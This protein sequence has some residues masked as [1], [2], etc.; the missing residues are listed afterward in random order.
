MTLP[1]RLLLLVYR[2]LWYGAVPLVLAYF[3]LRGRRDAAYRHHWGERFGFGPMLEGDR[4]S[5]V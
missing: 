2:A 1:Y 3:W 5:V 4:K